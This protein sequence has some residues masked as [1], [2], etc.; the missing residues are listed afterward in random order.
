[1]I[2][3]IDDRSHSL[4]SEETGGTRSERESPG[5]ILASVAS[6]AKLFRSNDGRFFAQ[7][8][9]GD[10]MEIYGLKSAAFRDWLI[11][12]YLIDQPEPPSPAAIRRAVGMLEARARFDADIPEVF[13]RTGRDG[14]TARAR[15]ISSTWAIPA[16]G[17]SRLA[18]AVGSPSIGPTV[19]FRRPDGQLPASHAQPR[20]LDRPAPALR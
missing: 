12:G 1:M 4:S 2:P 19:H 6:E 20:R 11:H 8:P 10:R 3:A 14:E 5:Q 17:P 13:V 15:R 9:V 18:I 16:A 7:V